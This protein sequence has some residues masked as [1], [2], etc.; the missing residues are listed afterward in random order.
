MYETIVDRDDTSVDSGSPLASG[1]YSASTRIGLDSPNTSVAPI[2]SS[3]N[4]P[5]PEV[6]KYSVYN[7]PRP[8]I[9]ATPSSV[10]TAWLRPFRLGQTIYISNAS[11]YAVTIERGRRGKNGSW[12]KPRGVYLSSLNKLFHSQGWY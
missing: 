7:L 1:H 12:Q 3:Y 11:A 9:R 4:Y 5:S 2:D 10:V 8:T 6:H